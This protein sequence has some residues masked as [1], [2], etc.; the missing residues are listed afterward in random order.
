MLDRLPISIAILRTAAL[1]VPG[2]RRVEW[3]AEWEAELWQV[4]RAYGVAWASTEP[5]GHAEIT[6]FCL[7]AFQD[8]LALRLDSIRYLWS[9]RLRAGSP[10]RLVM[11]L[12]AFVIA[13]FVLCLGAPALRQVAWKNLPRPTDSLVLL[14]AENN[15]GADAPTIPFADYRRWA[16]DSSPFLQGLAF[17]RPATASVRIEGLPGKRHIGYASPSMMDILRLSLKPNPIGGHERAKGPLALLS[18][19]IWRQD[20]HADAHVI[21]QNFL[22]NDQLVTIAGIASGDDWPVPGQMDIVVIESDAELAKKF[23][24]STGFVLAPAIRPAL[25]VEDPDRPSVLIRAASG[26]EMR[27]ECLSLAQRRENPRSL[28]LFALFL[29][30]LALPALTP[31]PL[32][33]YPD[34][35]HS[36]TAYVYLKR[37]SFLALKCALIL[38]TAFMTPLALSCRLTTA[39]TAAAAYLQISLSFLALLF[40]FRWALEDQRK[41]CPTCLRLLSHPALVGHSSHSFLAWSGTEL[42]CAGGHGFLHIPEHPTSWFST[43]RWLPLN[44]SWSELFSRA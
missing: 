37:W 13:A 34:C 19:R 20:F 16:A 6:A 32:G 18:Q 12:S 24:A 26:T 25:H 9:G 14:S 30:C 21:G 40:A 42:L 15:L 17:Y 5:H 23:S 22:V 29:A 28:F 2:C 3:F 8:A 27:L 7:G 44:A 43:Q 36:T 41:R 39:G 33:D 4:A 1:L 35:P 10:W 31:L 11:T 38:P